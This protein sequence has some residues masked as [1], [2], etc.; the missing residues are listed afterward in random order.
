MQP[1]LNLQQLLVQKETSLKAKGLSLQPHVIVVVSD[2]EHLDSISDSIA[3]AVI[4]SNLFFQMPSLIAALDTCIK[5]CFV[6]NVSFCHAAKSS[7]LFVQKCIF[8]INTQ[9]DN[10][11]SKVLQLVADCKKFASS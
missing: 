8:D 5:A 7:W 4:Q 9:H 2:I 11:G 3:Y 10:A 1:G 6:M